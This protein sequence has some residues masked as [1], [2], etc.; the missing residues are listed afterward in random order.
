MFNARNSKFWG[1][2][3]ISYSILLS[4]TIIMVVTQTFVEMISA[5]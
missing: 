4:I 1:V 3:L 5:M 2:F